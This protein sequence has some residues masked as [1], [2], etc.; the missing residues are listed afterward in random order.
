MFSA[1]KPPYLPRVVFSVVSLHILRRV[2]QIIIYCIFVV[3]I[4]DNFC[5]M[6]TSTYE[7]CAP[8][9]CEEY[10]LARGRVLS[11]AGRR[12]QRVC[13]SGGFVS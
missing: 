11:K 6:D 8:K 13:G 9:M 7:K 1:Q 5:F 12:R 4:I 2:Y 3:Q 10:K